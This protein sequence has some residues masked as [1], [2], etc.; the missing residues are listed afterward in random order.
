MQQKVDLKQTEPK[1]NQCSATT[2]TALKPQIFQRLKTS[3]HIGFDVVASS[4]VD[5][6]RCRTVRGDFF[7]LQKKNV[8]A[9]LENCY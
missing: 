1:S 2:F 6:G 9:K 4:V 3:L 7:L 5:E 8:W